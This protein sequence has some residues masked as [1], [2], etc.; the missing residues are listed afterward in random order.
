MLCHRINDIISWPDGTRPA[1]SYQCEETDWG[2]ETLQCKAAEEARAQALRARCVD[3]WAACCRNLDMKRK[4][5]ALLK[6][7]GKKRRKLRRRLVYH[8]GVQIDST[9]AS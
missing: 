6:Y 2:D 5:Q 8:I 9:Y 3:K 1:H 4:R 7:F